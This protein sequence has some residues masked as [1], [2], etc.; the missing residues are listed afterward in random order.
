MYNLFYEHFHVHKKMKTYTQKKDYVR[1]LIAGPS[2][3]TQ[4]NRVL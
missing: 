3:H 1:T 4:W 2:A